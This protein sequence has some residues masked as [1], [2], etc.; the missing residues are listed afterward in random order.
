MDENRI[1]H[2]EK[3]W[4][5]IWR[6]TIQQFPLPEKE[7]YKWLS[8]SENVDINE[9][10]RNP[11]KPWN[12]C[13]MLICNKKINTETGLLLESTKLNSLKIDY[14][15]FTRLN[16]RYEYFVDDFMISD[17]RLIEFIWNSISRGDIRIEDV[18]AHLEKP[19]NWRN[20]SSNKN[21]KMKDVLKYPDLDWDWHFLSLNDS[22]T[23]EDAIEHHE[24]PWSWYNVSRKKGI[25]IQTILDNPTIRWNWN[26]FCN[27]LDYNNVDIPIDFVLKNLEKPWNMSILSRL[28]SIKLSDIIRYPAINWNWESIS[29]NPSITMEDVNNNLEL[30]WH[31]YELSKNSSIT[32]E[33]ITDNPQH[34]WDWRAI[35]FNPNITSEFILANIDKPLNWNYLSFNENVD[36][37]LILTLLDKDWSFPKLISENSFSGSKK[38]YLEKK[39]REYKQNI[40]SV[41]AI[42]RNSPDIP[43]EIFSMICDFL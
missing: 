28:P 7:L 6:E 35:S 21:I 41:K 26:G 24:Q 34:P 23:V 8:Y 2:Y 29:D 17:E 15:E 4:N 27:S 32:M 18:V 20:L 12:L 5:K 36:M 14:I 3:E 16:H 11:D 13:A 1:K 30:N 9:F 19:W 40:E 10:L 38:R 33:N 25:T 43:P 22:I 39:E 31:W 37:E 42:Q